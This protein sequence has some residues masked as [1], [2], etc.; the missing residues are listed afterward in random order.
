MESLRCALFSALVVA[1][2]AAGSV[3]RA[4]DLPKAF[5]PCIDPSNLPFANTQGEGFE[6]HIAELFA[7]KLGLPVQNYAFPQRMNFIRNTLRYKL[8]DAD[9]SQLLE[10]TATDEGAGFGGASSDF[11]FAAAVAEFGLVLKNSEFK[12]DA[13]ME[14]VLEIARKTKGGDAGGYRAEFLN[15]V[16]KAQTLKPQSVWP[17][18]I[19]NSDQLPNASN[20]IS[21]R[22]RG[23]E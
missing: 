9:E 18:D 15:L 16:R 14:S 19:I 8:P 1:V 10:F 13:T 11:K 17:S 7:Q 3:A 5:R 2:I 20:R 21:D 22:N 6:N 23:F 4:E 12:G